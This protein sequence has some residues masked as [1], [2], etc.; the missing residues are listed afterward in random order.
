MGSVLVFRRRLRARSGQGKGWNI[1][2]RIK[3]SAGALG[4][5]MDSSGGS[6]ERSGGRPMTKPSWPSLLISM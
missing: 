1:R 5:E 2:S 4:V 6:G 3:S